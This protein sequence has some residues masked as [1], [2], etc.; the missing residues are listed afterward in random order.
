MKLNWNVFLYG[1]VVAVLG[2][3]FVYAGGEKAASDVIFW[4]LW[5]A[6]LITSAAVSAIESAIKEQ[7]N[8]KH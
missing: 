2:S 5:G 4:L 3:L 1:A 8:E 6:T 7:R